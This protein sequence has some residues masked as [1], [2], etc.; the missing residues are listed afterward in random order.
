MSRPPDL[1]DQSWRE[2]AACAG[3]DISVFF[4][5][6]SNQDARRVCA[7]CKVRE[8][9]L[10]YALKLPDCYGIWGGTSE[11]ERRRLLR[12]SRRRPR[13]QAFPSVLGPDLYRW[14]TG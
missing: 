1:G 6:F 12:Q 8:P 2:N 7:T 13:G 14:A 3:R 5:G 4:N 9:C 10:Q 11:E